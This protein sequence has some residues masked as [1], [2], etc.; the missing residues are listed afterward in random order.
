[1]GG[2]PTK[3]TTRLFLTSARA[4]AMACFSPDE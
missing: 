4:K 1:M 2:N 3:T